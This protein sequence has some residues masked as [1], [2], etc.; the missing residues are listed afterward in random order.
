[1]NPINY[2]FK[3]R[4]DIA[5]CR[6]QHDAHNSV[7]GVS[8]H[9]KGNSD[10]IR[11]TVVL[12]WQRSRKCHG[13]HSKDFQPQ[14]LGWSELPFVGAYGRLWMFVDDNFCLV[15]W[16]WSSSD[17][18]VLLLLLLLLMSSL[19]LLVLLSLLMLLLLLLMYNL[20]NFPACGINGVATLCSKLSLPLG[21]SAI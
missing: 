21:R 17:P 16:G 6:D 14:N 8:T 18:R 4:T 10:L 5:E 9:N 3:Q 15:V 11:S 7:R 12:Q 20:I 1:M 19:P 13:I 2:F